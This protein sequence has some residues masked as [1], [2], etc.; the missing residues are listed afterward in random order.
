MTAAAS[1]DEVGMLRSQL[2]AAWSE[3]QTLRRTVAHQARLLEHLHPE[4]HPAAPSLNCVYWQF[5]LAHCHEKSWAHHW[6][7]LMP[8]LRGLGTMPA[9]EITTV[10]WMRHLAARR[11]EIHRFG[12][13][14][15]DQTLN[16]ELGRLKHM[17]SWAVEQ[18]M[19]QFNPL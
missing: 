6:D 1:F 12:S 16:V 8:T 2:A 10:V 3:I 5:S 17:L 9:S 14:P 7:R 4:T 19:I 13:P 18:H 15:S 11:A